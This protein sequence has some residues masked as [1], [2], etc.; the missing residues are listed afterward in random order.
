MAARQPL[1]TAA[2]TAPPINGVANVM[3]GG[4]VQQCSAVAGPTPRLDCSISQNGQFLSWAQLLVDSGCTINVLNSKLATKMNLYVESVEPSEYDIQ[5][6]GGKQVK[7]VGR[8]DNIDAQ[9]AGWSDS[10]P[11]PLLVSDTLTGG[12]I[13]VS[14]ETGA[15]FSS[16]LELFQPQI[17]R[18]QFT[19]EWGR[20]R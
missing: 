5:D 13:L 2:A 17:R 8:A 18:D 11:L 12:D 10:K 4:S 6:A 15:F 20:S 16:H 9:L 7:I 14:W 3:A 19:K 1:H